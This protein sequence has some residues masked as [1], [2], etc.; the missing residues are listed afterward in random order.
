MCNAEEYLP[1]HSSGSYDLVYSFGVI[2]HTPN[3]LKIISNIANITTVGSELRIMLYSKWSYKLFW[4]LHEYKDSV[5]NFDKD[6]DNMVA[7]YAEAQTGCPIANTYTFD[8][9][10]KLLKPYFKIKKIWKDHIFP[11][12][13]EPYKQ[14]KFEIV[15]EFAN[16][17]KSRFNS[18]CKELGWHTLVIAERI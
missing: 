1:S 3:P 11:Y 15:K 16:M 8:E 7:R 9:I 10:K 4:I 12:K 5:W 14:G 18:M 17:D 6:M 2:H 13:I